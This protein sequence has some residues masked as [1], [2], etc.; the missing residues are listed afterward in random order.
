MKVY[1]HLCSLPSGLEDLCEH[2]ENLENLGATLLSSEASSSLVV[3]VLVRV[4]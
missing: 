2:L 4:I 1:I 3:F